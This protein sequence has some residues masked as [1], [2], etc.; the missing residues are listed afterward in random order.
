MPYYAICSQEEG[1]ID[2]QYR[3]NDI[4]AIVKEGGRYVPRGTFEHKYHR[5]V[6][7]FP[8]CDHPTR[9]VAPVTIPGN[10]LRAELVRRL[11]LLMQ[12]DE[13]E[14]SGKLYALFLDVGPA[15]A[16]PIAQAVAQ[17]QTGKE[18][19]LETLLLNKK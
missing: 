10:T 3:G 6:V 18:V 12:L 14:K 11:N 15:S 16:E 5:K 4:V 9:K 8:G 17:L 1:K 2:P 7:L 19:N 13:Y